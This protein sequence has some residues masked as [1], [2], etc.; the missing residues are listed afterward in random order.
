MGTPRCGQ[1]FR[2]SWVMPLTVLNQRVTF[3][4]LPPLNLSFLLANAT[5]AKTPAA[6]FLFS[7]LSRWAKTASEPLRLSLLGVSPTAGCGACDEDDEYL[8]LSNGSLRSAA[9]CSKTPRTCHVA[10]SWGRQ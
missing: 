10:S 1:V 5:P 4:W 2:S 7:P 6:S 9:A 3:E 8:A